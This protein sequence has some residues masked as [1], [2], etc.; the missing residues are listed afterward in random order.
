M[1]DPAEVLRRTWTFAQQHSC[2]QSK[3]SSRTIL[4]LSGSRWIK[5]DRFEST[6]L[7][8]DCLGLA[9]TVFIEGQAFS[10]AH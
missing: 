2:Q 7:D 9:F 10:K 5:P 1:L 3:Y 6:T 4:I 8:A